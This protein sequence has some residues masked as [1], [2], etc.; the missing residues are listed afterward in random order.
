MADEALRAL[1]RQ[2]TGD[3]ADE[4]RLLGVRLR[5]GRLQRARLEIAATL[6]HGPALD[7]L[8]AFPPTVPAALARWR[9]ALD[10]A[11]R[12]PLLRVPFLSL[13]ELAHALEGFEGGADLDV[14]RERLGLVRA[15][16][17]APGPDRAD[18]LAFGEDE[19]TE[20]V[21]RDLPRSARERLLDAFDV[22]LSRLRCSILC[23]LQEA[24]S[25]SKG[26]RDLPRLYPGAKGGYPQSL[27]GEV[28]TTREA[29]LRWA[30]G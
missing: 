18:R 20:D 3:P 25:L 16:L 7:A 14:R 19:G 6:G 1:E 30:L 29:I 4:V 9:A 27:A 12:A 15:W 8:D 10:E 2:Q 23:P 28:E 17:D 13:L 26:L 24:R 22:R 11:A 21:I 5:A